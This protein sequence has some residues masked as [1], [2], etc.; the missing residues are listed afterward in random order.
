MEER[1]RLLAL[2]VQR[3][4][5]HFVGPTAKP[6]VYRSYESLAWNHIR[7]HRFLST[8]SHAVRR[9]IEGLIERL[10]MENMPE[11]AS[12]MQHLCKLML[13]H[14]KWKDHYEVDV[15]WSIVDFLITMTYQPIQNIRN[16]R[17]EME[18]LRLAI[19]EAV[20]PP[21]KSLPKPT[22]EPDVNWEALLKED[23]LSLPAPNASNSSDTES[24]DSCFI[25]ESESNASDEFSSP[26]AVLDS[27]TSL[28]LK[29]MAEVYELAMNYPRDSTAYVPNSNGSGSRKKN[30][31]IMQPLTLVLKTT[32]PSSKWHRLPPLPQLEPPK[33]LVRMV[34]AIPQPEKLLK[35]AHSYWWR[36]DLHVCVQQNNLLPLANFAIAFAQFQRED[37]CHMID[38]PLP[39]TITEN[40]M[41]REIIFMF[42]RPASCCF[43]IVESGRI[44]V[45][46]NVTV[47]S[48]TVTTLNTTLKECILPAMQSM[49]ELQHMIAENTVLPTCG[50]L[51]CFAIALRQLIQPITK[52]L[53]K[54]ERR[55]LDDDDKASLIAFILYM[56]HD[57]TQLNILWHIAEQVVVDAESAPPHMRSCCLLS[58]LY[59]QMRMGRT[60]QKLATALLLSSMKFYCGIM[61]GWWR[62]AELEDWRREFIVE[63]IE[64]T[65]SHISISLRQLEQIDQGITVGTGPIVKEVE[66]CPMY[67]VLRRHAL[68]SAETQELL[69]RLN[70]LGN[71]L[72]SGHNLK[73]RNLYTD[74]VGAVCGELNE[75]RNDAS[76]ADLLLPTQCDKDI[77]IPEVDWSGQAK[78]MN[79][80]MSIIR[81]RELLSIICRS[82]E[83]YEVQKQAQ[84]LEK[85][86]V[87]LDDLLTGNACDLLAY[88]E[89]CT[90]MSLLLQDMV[91]RVLT[92][93][94]QHRRRFAEAFT[95]QLY[96]DE[97]QI[98][99][100]VRFLR[101]LM[102]LEADYLVY[103]F[104]TNLFRQIEKGQHWAHSS[105]LTMELYDIVA[106]HYTMA[107]ELHLE[108]VSKVRANTSKVYEA[109]DAIELVYDMELP[110]Q[111]IVSADNMVLYNSIWRLMLKVKWAAWKLENLKFIR[112]ADSRD[113][114]APLD[115]LGLTV[116][117]LEILRFWLMY[118]VNSLHTHLCTHVLQAMGE[119]FMRQLPKCTNI[120]ELSTMHNEYINVLA[121]HCL[122]TAEFADF[123]IALEQ[124]FHLVFVLDMEWI[125]CSNYL[126][127]S[128]ALTIETDDKNETLSNTSHNNSTHAMEYLALNQVVEI[129][130]TYIRCHQMLA[131]VLHNLVYKGDHT[132]L[133][134]LEVALNTSVPY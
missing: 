2:N 50:T 112:R 22:V 127:K 3:L 108:L 122:L 1:E 113:P 111:R 34:K 40:C 23:F 46:D 72:A 8:N 118:I 103:P 117:R 79:Q 60:H 58:R 33:E 67:Q 52:R 90:P 25:D 85:E 74:L 29:D 38:Y 57:F 93:L 28:S 120:G 80:E 129:E 61:D 36:P 83:N 104:Y 7:N 30:F 31:D 73:Q 18:K 54:F 27:L 124:L 134:A 128:H 24:N 42:F 131:K 64:L 87:T 130:M 77:S 82:I 53:L 45:R 105:L 41:L 56:R 126:N 32:T 11:Y 106:P 70:R 55:L 14:P 5:K 69:A 39:K 114:Y 17:L 91:V 86:R 115:L 116:R 109:V 75:Y 97:L 89:R 78:K 47:P 35:L 62:R 84:M 88:I 13:E 19:L 51:E 110:I 101:H 15:Q 123:R 12:T 76:S 68:E 10:N 65:D 95:M 98:G 94:L 96:R 71:M 20:K 100:H 16:N 6:A 48:V 66:Q 132:F 44:T 121:K 81:N 102:L 99:E 92:L 43:F 9:D 59:K 125:S 21:L 107:G 26:P 4:V 133:N 63:R 37:S 119:Q 49:A